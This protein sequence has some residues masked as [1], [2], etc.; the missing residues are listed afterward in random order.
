MMV[1][2]GLYGQ[3]APSGIEM[4]NKDGDA[5]DHTPCFHDSEFIHGLTRAKMKEKFGATSKP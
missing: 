3:K 2:G 1:I 4:K 5:N